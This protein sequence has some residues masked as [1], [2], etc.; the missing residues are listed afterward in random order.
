MLS[1]GVKKT[2]EQDFKT[3]LFAIIERSKGVL[4]LDGLFEHAFRMLEKYTFLKDVQLTLQKNFSCINYRFF[5]VCALYHPDLKSVLYHFKE[6]Y[7]PRRALIDLLF[8]EDLSR[9]GVLVNAGFDIITER[10]YC[11]RDHAD[12]LFDYG[13]LDIVDVLIDMEKNESLKFIKD[14][15]SIEALIQRDCDSE[16]HKIHFYK[17]L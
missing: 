17:H 5:D 8:K 1:Y 13:R 9:V 11:I 10:G 4:L 7:P 3:L 15:T 2:I 12:E 16:K 6:A 14:H